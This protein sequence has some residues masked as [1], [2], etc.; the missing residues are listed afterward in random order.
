MV[1]DSCTSIQ[2]KKK[3]L[4][5]QIYSGEDSGTHNNATVGAQNKEKIF[6]IESIQ[7]EIQD[8]SIATLKGGGEEVELSSRYV[9]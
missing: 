2:G 3:I 6:E 5:S 8:H 1:T 7:T 9:E 4:R